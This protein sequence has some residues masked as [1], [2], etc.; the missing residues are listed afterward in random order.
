[1]TT[2]L[3]PKDFIT[4]W[5]P[6]KNSTRP[7]DNCLVQME[8]HD[9]LK[10]VF[11]AASFAVFIVEC[12]MLSFLLSAIYSIFI[13]SGRKSNQ[14]KL[15]PSVKSQ[16]PTQRTV[17]AARPATVRMDSTEETSDIPS[18]RVSARTN[19]PFAQSRR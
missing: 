3:N 16:R 18:V 15:K 11:L 14:M 4:N 17:I 19:G 13:H 9:I 1:M 8:Y 2:K 12:L 5:R 10:I 7:F 6:C